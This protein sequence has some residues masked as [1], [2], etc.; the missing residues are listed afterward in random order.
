[1]AAVCITYIEEAIGVLK[2]AKDAGLQAMVSYT[3]E[4]DGKLPSGR[5]LIDPKKDRDIP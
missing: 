4:T 2:A 1:M 3:V 5:A